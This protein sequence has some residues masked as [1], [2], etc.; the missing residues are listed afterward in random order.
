MVEKSQYKSLAEW[1]K[2]NP[3]D[4]DIVRKYGW[5]DDIC[6]KFGW[7][8]DRQKPNG[9]WTLDKIIESIEN[10]N[11]ESRNKWSKTCVG[12]YN[13]AKKLGIHKNLKEKYWP[14]SRQKYKMNH[15]NDFN[16]I[17]EVAKKCKTISAFMVE[18]PSAYVSAKRNGCFEEAIAHME[19][20]I[21]KY[22]TKKTK[23]GCEEIADKCENLKEFRT[24]YLSLYNYAIKQHWYDE[25]KIKFKLK[26]F[27]FIMHS[28]EQL[29]DI[30]SGYDT[31]EHFKNNNPK[32]YKYIK[33]KGWFNELIKNGHLKLNK[34][35][36]GY[37][38]KMRCIE[39]AKG[40]TKNEWRKKSNSAFQSAYRN[41]WMDEISKLMKW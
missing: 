8:D 5:V 12:A 14:N 10:G 41:G 39:S 11:F 4:F 27:N 16:N 30:L 7:V 28:K 23:E 26:D 22:E 18:Y 21:N 15:W 2:A 36:N 40:K 35:A 17:F 31:L 38:N 20:K 25:F 13:A 1:R 34:K 37:W 9:Y 24:Q 29:M 19:S 6:E 32:I 3:K 33:L